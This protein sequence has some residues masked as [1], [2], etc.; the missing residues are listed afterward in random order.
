MYF[1]LILYLTELLVENKAEKVATYLLIPN[2]IRRLLK[3]PDNVFGSRKCCSR[4][5]LRSTYREGKNQ[6]LSE[7]VSSKLISFELLYPYTQM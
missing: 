1:L 3:D 7:N 4:R 2:W 6:K 5:E